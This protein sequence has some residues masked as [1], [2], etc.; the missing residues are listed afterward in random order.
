MGFFYL[1]IFKKVIYKVMEIKAEFIDLKVA[2]PMNGKPVV[3]RFLN[4]S[5]YPR[6]N[7]VYPWVFE[8]K[9]TKR[10]KDVISEK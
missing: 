2:N 7:E 8:T 6:Y 5:L 4:K 3:L 10:K 1:V 9:I